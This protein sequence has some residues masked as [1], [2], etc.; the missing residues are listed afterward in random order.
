MIAIQMI[1]IIIYESIC[2][3]THTQMCVFVCVN[4]V[5]LSNSYTE[6][7][8]SIVMVF[9]ARAIWKELVLKVM[10]LGPFNRE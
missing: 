4:Y 2:T 5:N 3:H 6:A 8:L 9:V 1:Q 7:P 10:R